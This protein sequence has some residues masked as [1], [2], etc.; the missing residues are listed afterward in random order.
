MDI[1]ELLGE[2]GGD[3]GGHAERGGERGE[4]L[5]AQD[6]AADF[7]A[8]LLVGEALFGEQAIIGGLIELAADLEGGDGGDDGADGAVAGGEA[9]ASGIFLHRGLAD[10]LIGDE[11]DGTVFGDIGERGC[12]ICAAGVLEHPVK[13]AGE[14]GLDKGA[15]ADDR[16]RALLA[17][18]AGER[19]ANAGDDEGDE[20][21]R[22]H[23]ERDGAGHG[24]AEKL[25]HGSP[26]ENC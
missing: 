14:I 11:R 26:D 9:D 20:D 21:Q 2:R 4:E 24:L 18:A 7:L 25:Q 5:F 12:G 19:I 17:S 16:D 8:Q 23:P 3:A 1:D 6:I 22:Q 10:E 15:V 13:G